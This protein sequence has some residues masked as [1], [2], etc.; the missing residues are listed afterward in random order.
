MS[1]KHADIN[2]LRDLGFIQEA[3]RLFFHPHGLALEVTVVTDE[4]GDRAYSTVSLLADD[5]ATLDQLIDAERERRSEVDDNSDLDALSHRIAEAKHHA[6]GDAWI[7]GVWDFREDPEGILFGDL[8]DDKAKKAESVAS[9]RR[10]YR[11]AREALFGGTDVEP[12]DYVYVEGE[13]SKL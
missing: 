10:L 11:G 1:V 7:S 9:Y 5:K 3:N 8:P 13:A 12:L 4:Q 2:K 6:V